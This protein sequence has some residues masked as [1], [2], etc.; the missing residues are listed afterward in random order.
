VFLGQVAERLRLTYEGRALAYER[1]AQFRE[2]I[3]LVAASLR[4]HR[5]AHAGLQAVRQL[6]WRIDTF[7]FHVATLDLR[8]HATVH[9]EVLAQGLDDPHWSEHT[10]EQRTQGYLRSWTVISGRLAS[11]ML[12]DG[13]P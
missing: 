3:A 5:G 4:D 13:A 12:W 1:P 9:H 6:L 10:P 11:L 8:Q 7:G 2:D